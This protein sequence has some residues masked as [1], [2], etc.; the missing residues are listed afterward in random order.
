MNAPEREPTTDQLLAMAYVD[1]E[2]DEGART[3]LEDRMASAPEIAREVAELQ[4]LAVLT[5]LV[6]PAEPMD[7]E[8]AR[9]HAEPTQRAGSAL[10]WTLVVIGT[11]GVVGWSLWLVFTD[12][13]T[14]PLFRGLFGMAVTGFALLFLLVAKNRLRTLPLDPYR[15][16]QR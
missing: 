4:R 10:A 3:E 13:S 5:R 8:W 15:D 11:L 2:L 6:A 1:G 9:I 16:V 7:H 14:S 12:E